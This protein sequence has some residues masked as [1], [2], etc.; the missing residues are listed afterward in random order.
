M[1]IPKTNIIIFLLL[2]FVGFVFLSTKNN[3]EETI[4]LRTLM[5]S[6]I[7]DAKEIRSLIKDGDSKDFDYSKHEQILIAETKNKKATTPY[8]KTRAENYLQMVTKHNKSTDKKKSFNQL[9][10]ACINCHDYAS[11]VYIGR[12]KKLYINE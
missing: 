6:I 10:D 8:F 4:K 5:R 11:K 7:S 9:I 3:E 12:I 2:L 1:A